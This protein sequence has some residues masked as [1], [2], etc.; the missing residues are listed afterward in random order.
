[1]IAAGGGLRLAAGSP[2]LP[3]HLPEPAELGSLLGNA[4]LPLDG[5]AYALTSLTWLLWLWV[6]ASLGLELGLAA[7][8]SASRGAAWVGR[9]RWASNHVTLP[10]VRRA[11]AA[12]FAVQ[13]LTR[14]V[15][16]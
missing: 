5:V 3:D 13:V 4:A 16:V 8:E 7:L 12:A 2:R 15:P 10:L 1:M 9:V 6:I 14:A 11:V